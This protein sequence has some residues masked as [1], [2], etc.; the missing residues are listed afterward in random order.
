MIGKIKMICAAVAVAV[1]AVLAPVA[2][3]AEG[4]S[5]ST[6]SIPQEFTQF[7]F[8][9]IVSTLAS[10]LIPGIACALGLAGGIWGI[11]LL[12]RKFRSLGK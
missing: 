7:D 2:A 9:S 4:S 6:V 11:S 5:S 12:W 1:G 8:T 3:F 10:M